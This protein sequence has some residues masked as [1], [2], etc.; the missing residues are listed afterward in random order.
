MENNSNLK[1][2]ISSGLKNIIG[3]QLITDKYIAVFELV[4]NSYDALAKHVEITFAKDDD[5]KPFIKISDD[6]YGMSKQDIQDKWLFVAYSEKKEKNQDSVTKRNGIQRK[7]AG[8]KGIGRFSCDR[9]GSKLSIFTKIKQDNGIHQLNINWDEFEEDDTKE[10]VSI[11]AEYIDNVKNDLDFSVGTTLIITGLREEWNRD[12][13]LELKKSLMKLIDPSV[14]NSSAKFS[15]S[16]IVP[17]EEENDKKERTKPNYLSRNIVNGVIENDIFEKLNLRTTSI[18]VNIDKSGKYINTAL[19]DRGKHVFN[20]QEKN[21]QFNT[22]LG[23]QIKLFYLNQSAK[24]GFSQ[25]MGIQPKDYGS[26]FVYKNGFR[27]YPYGNPEDDFFGINLRKAQGY[28]RYLGTRE[29]I[30]RISIECDDEHFVETSSRAFGFIRSEE[31]KQLETFFTERVL[32]VLERYVVEVIA[33]GNA[34][35]GVEQDVLKTIDEKVFDKF[36][37]SKFSDVVKVSINTDLLSGTNRSK[38]QFN[39]E[40]D[41]IRKKALSENDTQT[42]KNTQ[43]IQENLKKL[44]QLNEELSNISKEHEQALAAVQEENETRKKQVFFLESA[45]NQDVNDLLNLYHTIYTLAD[46]CIGDIDYFYKHNKLGEFNSDVNELLIKLYR[47]NSKVKKIA[48]MVIHGN[49]IGNGFANNVK[50][51][52]YSFLKEYVD[53]NCAMSDLEY[54]FTCKT[55]HLNCLFNLVNMGIVFDNI[56][57]NSKKA[58]GKNLSIEFTEDEKFVIVTFTD[59]GVGLDESFDIN[60]IFEFG[61]SQNRLKKG[62]GLGLPGI[63]KMVNDMKGETFVDAKYKDG[64]RIIVRLKK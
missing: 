52:I 64:F 7:M 59:D 31:L 47:V 36:F 39:K 11:N 4:K 43:K 55:K 45:Q 46:A 63:K 40:I 62:F 42:L 22:L 2:K 3:R 51:D 38:G 15:I 14:E 8:S 25:Q 9:L 19:F 20:V 13:I 37:N 34:F 54:H 27:I 49:N 10:F 30:G 48:D 57:S 1:F 16:I 61:Y 35:D 26:V 33:W 12:G 24:T 5:G 50:N 23:I 6:G 29:I 58:G 53:A 41:E 18:E 21:R 44:K 32:K 28:S 56:C 60:N 17:E